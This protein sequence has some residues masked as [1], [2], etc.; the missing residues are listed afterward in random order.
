[1]TLG[2]L[3]K[4]IRE[5]KCDKLESFV[6]SLFIMISKRFFLDISRFFT[7]RDFQRYQENP[8]QSS[9]NKVTAL[10]S[11]SKNKGLASGTPRRST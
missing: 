8:N 4:K 2:G 10:Q 5:Q 11:W 7:S 3:R 1:M 6:H 9:D